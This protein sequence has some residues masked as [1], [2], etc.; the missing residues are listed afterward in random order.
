MSEW[1]ILEVMLGQSGGNLRMRL[2]GWGQVWMV[3]VTFGLTL[4]QSGGNLRMHWGGWGQVWVVLVTFGSCWVSPVAI[5]VCIGAAVG[6][7]GW[8]W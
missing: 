5:S 7:S 6:R 8:F 4:G 1:S 3:L 2:G